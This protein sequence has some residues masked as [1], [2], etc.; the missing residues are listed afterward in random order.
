MHGHNIVVAV[1]VLM[2][3]LLHLAEIRTLTSAV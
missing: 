3:K 1:V 2:F